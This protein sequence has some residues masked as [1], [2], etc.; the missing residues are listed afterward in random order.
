MP[1]RR[2][3]QENPPGI[4]TEVLEDEAQE[5]GIVATTKKTH[6]GLKHRGADSAECGSDSRNDQENP[7][8]IETGS[9]DAAMGAASSVAT[10]KKTHQGLKLL[11]PAAV[12]L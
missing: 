8:G 6:Q 11:L 7:P 4:E 12:L 2:N 1:A 10:T 5:I 3:D 9:F